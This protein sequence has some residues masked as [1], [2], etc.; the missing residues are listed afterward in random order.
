MSEPVESL[1]ALRAFIAAADA[2][3]FKA[4]GQALGVSSSAIGKSIAKLEAQLSTTLFHRTTRTIAL[5]EP[6]SLFL[7]RAR[8][9]LDELA[10]AEAEL[11]EASGSPRGRL[12]VGLP[13]SGS[14]LTK[15]FAT[16]AEAYP[17]VELDLDYS[18]RLVDVIDEGFDVV[19][20]SGDT[21]D[22]RLL[23]KTLGRFAW[24]LVASP[25]YLARHGRPATHQDLS[26][27]VCLRQRLSSG[28]IMPWQLRSAPGHEVPVGLTASVIDPL[29]DLARAGAGIASLPDFLLHEALADG[30]LVPVLEAEMEQT[31]VL[32]M[33]WP[34]SRF[35]V[36][37][38]RAFVD[39]MARHAG[40]S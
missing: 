28:R 32:T 34:A 9:M 15:A 10:A 18:D 22:S 25:S 38:V 8:R 24:R 19:I 2:R 35:R 12:R 36:P 4:A 11:A 17:R 31:G 39:W 29:L 40:V 21:G 26:Q 33:L 14:L 20:R 37:K 23:H 5:T 3:S 30:S 6:G 13:L 7:V 1:G 27:H 16:F